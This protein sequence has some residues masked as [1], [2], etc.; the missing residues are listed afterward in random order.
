VRDELYIEQ[1]GV[2]LDE[3]TTPESSYDVRG[4]V[5]GSSR[6]GQA[7]RHIAELYEETTIIFMDLASFTRW[8]SSR[9]PV[10]VFNFSEAVYG[11][12]GKLARRRRVFKIKHDSMGRLGA[13]TEELDI[14]IGIHSGTTIGGV[15]R[16]DKGRFQLFG[17]T[18]N[19][20][21]RMES[22]GVKGR[23]HKPRRMH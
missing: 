8:S 19:T 17:D 2:V 15:L 7:Y 10:E 23:V 1:K 16:G 14:R 12:F 11:E 18:V 3:Q 6:V 20:A 5:V 9:T 22:N 4:K 21:S 13:D